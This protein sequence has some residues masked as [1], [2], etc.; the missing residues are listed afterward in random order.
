MTKN[1]SIKPSISPNNSSNNTNEMIE[2]YILSLI[3]PLLAKIKQELVDYLLQLSKLKFSKDEFIPIDVV[4]VIY[5][6]PSSLVTKWINKGVI[7]KYYLK[8]SILVSTSEIKTII[9]QLVVSSRNPYNKKIRKIVESIKSEY[10][11]L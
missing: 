6:I 4:P 8:D 11:T 9:K 5:G 2:L 7:N 3:D 1:N 10:K